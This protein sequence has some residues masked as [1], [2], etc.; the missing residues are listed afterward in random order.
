MPA[1]TIGIGRLVRETLRRLKIPVAPSSFEA[2][3]N[4]GLTSQIPTGRVI[5]VRKRVRRKLG[6]GNVRVVLERVHRK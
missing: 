2:Q 4:M 3:Y 6:Y 1:P 5:G